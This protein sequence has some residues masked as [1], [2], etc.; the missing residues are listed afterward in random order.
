[1]QKKL[2]GD[3]DK[4][5]A[6]IVS[7]QDKLGQV[8]QKI[9]EHERKILGLESEYEKTNTELGVMVAANHSRFAELVG[10]EC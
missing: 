7:L 6:E 5:A 1:M 8:E 3:R 4:I 10:L 2:E 9:G